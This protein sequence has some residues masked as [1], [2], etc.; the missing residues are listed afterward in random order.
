MSALQSMPYWALLAV[1]SGAP[2]P[3]AFCCWM[4]IVTRRQ[5]VKGFLKDNQPLRT[6]LY[7]AKF[8]MAALLC[9]ITLYSLLYFAIA[10]LSAVTLPT[11]LHVAIALVPLVIGSLCGF[12]VVLVAKKLVN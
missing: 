3:L 9:A 6:G 2:V 12:L 8:S 10:G 11:S 5:K 1:A 4:T 7:V